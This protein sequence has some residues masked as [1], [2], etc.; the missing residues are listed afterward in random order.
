[1][2][3]NLKMV[4]SY[5][6]TAYSGFQSQPS[7]N[8]IQDKLV[9]A[10]AALTGETVKITG[11]GRTDAGVHARGQVFNFYTD[12]AIPTERWSLAINSRLPEDISVLSTEQV[13]ESFH[14]RRLAKRKTYRYTIQRTRH[15]DVF[16]RRTRFHHP[17]PL[18]IEEM[19]K[20]L[21]LLE[22]KHD[23]TSFCTTRRPD[24]SHVRTILKAKIVLEDWDEVGQAGVIHIEITGSGFLHNM[25]RIIVGTLIEIGEGK[26]PSAEMAEILQ[27]CNRRRAGPT[28]MAHGLILWEVVY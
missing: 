3:K 16:Y 19:R 13:P 23:F 14:A 27:A 9:E 26:R 4:V 5:D 18:A 17:T 25:V 10:I 11:S 1:M 28:A 21:A 2:M 20:A 12:S 22:G 6:G 7:R 8:T 24:G 15:P